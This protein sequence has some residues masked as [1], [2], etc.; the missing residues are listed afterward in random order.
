MGLNR[1]VRK[2]AVR[3]YAN[4]GDWHHIRQ[5]ECDCRPNGD[6]D[7]VR[8]ASLLNVDGCSVSQDHL[9]DE[10][11]LSLRVDYRSQE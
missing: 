6:M 7:L 2:V 8:L 5:A 4:A 1:V 10:V 11:G 3:L 9:D